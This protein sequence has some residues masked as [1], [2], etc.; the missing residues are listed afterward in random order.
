[1]SVEG[2]SFRRLTAYQLAV[3][4][5]GA[6]H[7][8]VTAWD[9]FERWTIGLQLVRAA[10][11]IGANI[12]EATGRWHVAD[13]RRLLMIARGS[14]YETEHWIV[15]AQERRLLPQDAHRPLGE[16]ARTL[17]GLIKRQPPE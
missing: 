8:A 7:D 13:R 10:D 3:A 11:S 2:S 9:S 17:N 6:L 5:A 16:I 4:L 14:L 15:Q 12:A 1:V